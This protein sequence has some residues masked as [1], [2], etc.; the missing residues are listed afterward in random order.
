MPH[1]RMLRDQRGSN[2]VEMS[3]ALMVLIVLTLGVCDLGVA[4]WQW[5]LAEKA[6]QA[7]ARLAAVS[8]P[9]APS[10]VTWEGDLT[11]YQGGTRCWDA[12]GHTDICA[13]A[14]KVITCNSSGCGGQTANAAAFKAIVT[15]MQTLLPKIQ[16]ANVVVEYT[17]NGLGFIGRPGGQ[18]VDVTVR[19]TGMTFDFLVLDHLVGLPD[20]ITMPPA[21][22]TLTGEDYNSAL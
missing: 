11:K 17:Y 16:P 22:A 13:P 8:D 5:N 15:R 2:T 6:T 20:K 9:V 3:I 4:L 10:I 1:F 21:T 7:G 19:L 18:P 14:T 12:V